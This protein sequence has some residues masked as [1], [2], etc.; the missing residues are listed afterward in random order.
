ML[1]ENSTPK[2]NYRAHRRGS[3]VKAESLRK[4]RNLPESKGWGWLRGDIPGGQN[5]KC[6]FQEMGLEMEY[7]IM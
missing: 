1:V 3:N 6:E 4:H 7:F 2:R 5:S